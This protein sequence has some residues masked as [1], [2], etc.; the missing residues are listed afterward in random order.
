MNHETTKLIPGL[1]DLQ[2]LTP[3]DLGSLLGRSPKSIV[4]D[5]TQRPHTLP[6]RFRVPGVRANRWRLCDVRDWMEKLAG[7]V[8]DK[9]TEVDETAR[10][11]GLDPADAGKV[12]FHL[13]HKSLGAAANERG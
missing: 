2:L 12:K 9:Q 6:P 10:K 3:E 11:A 8:A 13:G 7:V 1:S 5:A 4:F